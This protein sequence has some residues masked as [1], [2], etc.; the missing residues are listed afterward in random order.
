[1]KFKLLLIDHDHTDA[2]FKEGIHLPRIMDI[3]ILN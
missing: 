1:M 3:F 2:L